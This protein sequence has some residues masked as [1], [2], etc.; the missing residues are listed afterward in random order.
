VLSYT[1]GHLTGQVTTLEEKALAAVAEKKKDT[2]KSESEQATGG[3][4]Q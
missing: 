4:S 3:D 2:D 1:C